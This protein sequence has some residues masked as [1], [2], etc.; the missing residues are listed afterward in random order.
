MHRGGSAIQKLIGLQKD[1]N[2]CRHYLF[3]IA[4]NT[5]ACKNAV[6]LLQQYL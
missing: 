5:L 1:M 3:N 4:S 6:E 2:V